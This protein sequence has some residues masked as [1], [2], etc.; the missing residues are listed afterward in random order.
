MQIRD[1]NAQDAQA[2]VE[3]IQEMARGAG[4]TSSLTP[5][6]V[7]SYLSYPVGSVLLAIQDGQVLGLLSYSVRPD[8]YHAGNCGL[9]EEIVVRGDARRKGVGSALIEAV[10]ERA[11]NGHWAEVGLGVMPDN[12]QAIKLYKKLGFT[13]E[14][15]LL[16]QHL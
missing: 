14:A 4:E 7:Q 15:I 3:L 13:D 6:Y 11:R 2:I 1:A 10:L 9:I 16:E 8:L 12:E 5:D